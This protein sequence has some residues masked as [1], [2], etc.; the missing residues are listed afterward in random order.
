MQLV[1]L[2]YNELFS[3]KEADNVEH[4]GKYFVLQRNVPV[5]LL[6]ENLLKVTMAAELGVEEKVLRMASSL[7]P[8]QARTKG[9]ANVGKMLRLVANNPQMKFCCAGNCVHSLERATDVEDIRCNMHIQQ[10]VARMIGY[11]AIG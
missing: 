2:L 1:A 6:I 5:N 9:L 8:V 4:L 7:V 11:R 3:H 10:Q